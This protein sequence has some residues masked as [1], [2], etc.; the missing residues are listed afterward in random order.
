MLMRRKW[1]RIG[2]CQPQSGMQSPTTRIQ[3]QEHNLRHQTFSEIPLTF[4]TQ[5]TILL[6]LHLDTSP[7]FRSDHYSE[8]SHL[9]A[10]HTIS[11]N[12]KSCPAHRGSQP[13]LQQFSSVFS[14]TAASRPSPGLE[15][16]SRKPIYLNNID[17]IAS[18]QITS[19]S[20][21]IRVP[22]TLVAPST[23]AP[24]HHA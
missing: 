19:S 20:H 24:L 15:C 13:S 8:L 17:L 23:G 4:I 10:N 2:I 7:S 5:C 21:P 12:D 14:F 16:P 11:P 9:Q 18:H 22:A 6:L 1:S 3:G